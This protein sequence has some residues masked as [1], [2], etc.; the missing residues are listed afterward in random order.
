MQKSEMSLQTFAIPAIA[1]LVLFLFIFIPSAYNV[2]QRHRKRAPGPLSL[3]TIGNLHI[4]GTLP[5][6]TLQSLA[7]KYGP[8]M[9]LKL[10]QVPAIVV[11]SPEFAQ[12]FLKTHDTLFASRPKLQAAEA[13][14]LGNKGFIISEYGSY[15]RN[16]RKLC[17]LHLLS[18]SKVEMFGPLRKEELRLC[19]KSLKDASALHQVVDLTDVVGELMENIVC[20]MILGCSKD[21]RFDLKGL[22]HEA[23]ILIG[24]FN[25]ADYIP[26]LRVFDLQGLT[27]RLKK[28]SG[29]FDQ[30]LEQIIHDHEHS[31]NY[32][33]HRGSNNEDFVDILLSIMHQPI[34]LQDEKN[35]LDRTNIKAIIFEIITAAFDTSSITVEWAKSELLRHPN[36]MK[37]LQEE[38]T[39]VVGMKKQVEEADLENLPYLSMVVK[40]TLRLYPIAPLIL[41]CECREDVTIDGYYIK[42][43]TRVI[44]N[45]WA[46]GR[47]SRVWPNAEM[48]DPERFS[49]ADTDIRGNDFRV[50]PFGLGRRGCPG[51]HLGLTTV[52]VVLAQ[53]VHCFNWTLPLGVSIDDL[54]MDE[55]FGLSMPRNKH[56]LAM[57]SYRL[58][59]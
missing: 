44:V 48:F 17:T 31:S 18:A 15:W 52:K 7:K 41:P 38:L 4:L 34:N 26:W 14:T 9:S 56:L 32:N 51:I 6:R 30:A 13:L 33:E 27:R 25:L 5:H 28:V 10:G 37:R 53:L 23:L 12:L 19:V 24:T 16:V 2:N 20:K 43:K 8:I 42:K 59:V 11:S 45:A 36:V 21:D 29:A 55:K 54:D 1:I 46:I 3:P 35:L 47:D 40:E 50:I 49:N 39:S 22:T 58:I 57:P